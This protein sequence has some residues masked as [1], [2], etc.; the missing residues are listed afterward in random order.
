M[1]ST[2]LSFRLLIIVFFALTISSIA[3][4]TLTSVRSV[5]AQ[6]SCEDIPQGGGESISANISIQNTGQVSNN[7]L[8]PSS[9]W[10]NINALATAFGQCIG[11]TLNCQQSPCI[12]QETGTIYE[13]TVNHIGV[14]V[15]ISTS[16]SLNGTY[17]VGNVYGKNPNGSTAFFHELDTSASNST[18]PLGFLLSTPGTYTFRINAIINTTPCNI[19]P[20]E[21]NQ[22]SITV[23]VGP[24]DQATNNAESSC[25]TEVGEPVNVT[26]AT[27]TCNRLII[28]CPDL[29]LGSK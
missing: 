23:S 29:E 27:C 22:I 24:N 25:E 11:M 8:V 1:K 20:G 16:G 19:E 17:F 9:T 14:F 28:V 3:L 21:T 13:R 4:H 7:G 5:E 26:N 12:C 10:I 18:G 15:D 2:P 6:Q